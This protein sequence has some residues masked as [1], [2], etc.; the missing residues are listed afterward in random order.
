[1]PNGGFLNGH[2]LNVRGGEVMRKKQSKIYPY[3]LGLLTVGA[4]ALMLTSGV[5][6]ALAQ[7]QKDTDLDGFTD[8][9]ETSGIYLTGTGM[10][11]AAYPNDK[12]VPPCSTGIS[13]DECVDPGTQ[14][15]FVIIQ[16]ANGCPTSQTCGDP[17]SPLF[18]TSDIP[19][20]WQYANTYNPLALIYPGLGVATHE[21]QTSG[22]SQA[23]GGWYAVK[24]V[25]NLNPCSNL[26]G[27]ATFGVPYP[28]SVATI[29]PEK[30]MNWIDKT[31]SQ[32]CF[33][34]NGDGIAE[35]CYGPNDVAAFQCKNASSTTS[36]D[37]RATNPDLTPLYYEF[38]ENVFSHEVSHM[39]DL[40]SGSGTA[41]DHHWPIAYGYLME[42][43]IG[44]KVTRS[45]KKGQIYITV[46]L[47]IS[48][49]YTKQ[50]KTQHLLK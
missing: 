49:G 4:F 33:D 8:S 12:S 28:G 50:D 24:I 1:M 46:T 25:E 15:L 5:A 3:I 29:W 40:A 35:T 48:T 41:A 44:T 47:Y 19:M 23:I 18:G 7:A 20:P 36:I 6:G 38:F 37:M 26:M 21:L 10:S 17:C 39:M 13:R 43:F 9:I 11:L 30:I 34:L 27:L 14:D 42:Q 45:T 32:A 16:R 22:T 2:S 31:C